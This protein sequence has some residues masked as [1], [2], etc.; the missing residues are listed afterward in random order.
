MSDFTNNIPRNEREGHSVMRHKA[1]NDDEWRAGLKRAMAGVHVAPF[2][3]TPR[4]PKFIPGMAAVAAFIVAFWGLI[5]WAI[6]SGVAFTPIAGIAVLA[7]WGFVVLA[8][9]LFL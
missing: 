4:P 8:L 7:F 9:W 2:K 5:W 1:T 3:A 6:S